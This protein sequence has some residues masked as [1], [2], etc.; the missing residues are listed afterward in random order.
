MNK[1]LRRLYM[2]MLDLNFNMYVE[3]VTTD[4]DGTITITLLGYASSTN[5]TRSELFILVPKESVTV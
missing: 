2:S 1:D 3:R 5:T 4:K